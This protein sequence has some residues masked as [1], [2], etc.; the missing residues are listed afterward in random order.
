MEINHWI[1]FFTKP[2]IT[3]VKIIYQIALILIW[4]VHT[5]TGC[6]RIGEKPE[7]N[8][9]THTHSCT[10]H[11]FMHHTHTLKGAR[12]VREMGNLYKVGE[13]PLDNWQVTENLEGDNEKPWTQEAPNTE[14]YF[15]KAMWILALFHRGQSQMKWISIL[16]SETSSIF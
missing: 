8:S 10:T 3:T 11:T 9:R 14:K 6:W 16:N 15:W 4:R 5:L 2:F 1:P 7:W 13:K 12:S